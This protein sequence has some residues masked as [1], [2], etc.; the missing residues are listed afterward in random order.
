MSVTE[1]GD[2]KGVNWV[3]T[4]PPCAVNLAVVQPEDRVTRGCEEIL[5]HVS[6]YNSDETQ[7]DDLLHL[8]RHLL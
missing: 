3:L 5:E 8:G 6:I 2:L 1:G 7:R 4:N